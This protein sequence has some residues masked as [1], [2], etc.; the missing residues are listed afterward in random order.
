VK[1]KEF[2]CVCVCVCVC[3]LRILLY[4]YVQ[5]MWWPKIISLIVGSAHSDD[6]DVSALSMFHLKGENHPFMGI[7]SP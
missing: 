2:V 1:E 3:V 4:D 6:N 5:I 7:F